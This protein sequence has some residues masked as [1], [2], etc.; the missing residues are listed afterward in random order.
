MAVHARLTRA[1]PSLELAICALMPLD[2]GLARDVATLPW[3]GATRVASRG[4][5][6]LSS[7]ISDLQLGAARWVKPDPM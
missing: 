4:F 2:P 5:A 6:G 3:W 7:D 1:I